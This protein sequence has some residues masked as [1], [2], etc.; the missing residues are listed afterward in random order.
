MSRLFWGVVRWPMYWRRQAFVV[1]TAAV[2][3]VTAAVTATVAQG[4]VVVAQARVD[5]VV[6]AATVGQAAVHRANADSRLGD[7]RPPIARL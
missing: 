3:T 4:C 1:G 5:T 2:A 7:T 6:F